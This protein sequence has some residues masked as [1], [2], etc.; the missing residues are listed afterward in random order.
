[1]RKSSMGQFMGGCFITGT[2]TGVGKTV[3]TAGLAHWLVARHH[4]VGVMKPVETGWP[5]ARPGRSDAARL[6]AACGLDAPLERVCPYRFSAPLAPYGAA[7][8]AHTTIRTSVIRRAFAALRRRYP[9][10]LVE[11][12]GGILVPVTKTT[13][14]ID[15]MCDLELP[16]L[17]VGQSGLG[18]INQAL[19]TL[20]TLRAR[21]IPILALMLNRTSA[22]RGI[23]SRL[24]EQSTVRLLKERVGVPVLGPVRYLTRLGRSWPSGLRPLTNDPAIHRLGRLILTNGRR[25]HARP[26]PRRRLPQ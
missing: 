25:I 4:A 16:V 6:R 3:V 23:R 2:D 22:A 9:L 7:R 8:Q 14:M 13:T 15:L 21:R 20:E 26:S 1:M 10:M 18:G 5:T 24:Q 19:L 12:A 17:V 11:G